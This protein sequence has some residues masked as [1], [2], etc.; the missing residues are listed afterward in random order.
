M[1]MWLSFRQP[2]HELSF[3]DSILA[4]ITGGIYTPTSVTIEADIV[5]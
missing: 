4:G 5:N 1:I 2:T 3:V